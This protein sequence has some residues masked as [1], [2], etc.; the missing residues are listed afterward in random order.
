MRWAVISPV[1]VSKCSISSLVGSRCSQSG[2]MRFISVAQ[3][4]AEGGAILEE[5]LVL[6]QVAQALAL[7]PAVPQWCYRTRLCRGQNGEFDD[8]AVDEPV[9]AAVAVERGDEMLPGLDRVHRFVAV[10]IDRDDAR[11]RQFG[12]YVGEALVVEQ[13]VEV[14]ARDAPIVNV[15]EYRRDHRANFAQGERAIGHAEQ[16]QCDQRVGGHRRNAVDR[17]GHLEGHLGHRDSGRISE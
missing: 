14:S 17:D 1:E 12:E 3:L 15:I 10:G 4:V 6:E 16:G 8:R 11:R 7:G 5:E 2:S 13:W 9:H